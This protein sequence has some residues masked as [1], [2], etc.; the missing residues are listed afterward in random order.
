MSWVWFGAGA[1]GNVTFCPE[2]PVGSDRA[3]LS[4]SV[5]NDGVAIESVVCLGMSDQSRE[6]ARAKLR[7]AFELLELAERMFRRRLRR[8]NP[9]LSDEAVEEQVASWY[10]NARARNTAMASG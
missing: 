3:R 4:P 8:D 10:A 5:G 1:H 7:T 6:T 2:G 9:G